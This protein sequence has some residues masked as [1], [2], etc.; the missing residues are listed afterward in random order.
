[1]N[2]LFNFG[3]FFKF[4]GKNKLYTLID[5]FGLSVSLMFVILIAI[6]TTQEL[7]TDRFHAKAD[8]I[9]VL[10]NDNSLGSAY[11][12]AY[13]I[14]ER[15]P[16][17]EKVCPV[18]SLYRQ[19]PVV[20][21]ETKLNTELLFADSTFFD[22]F[23]FKLQT[24][25]PGQTLGARNYAV[26]SRTFARKAFGNESPMGKTIVLND[27]VTVVVNGVMDDIKNSTLPYCDILVRIDNVKHFNWTLDSETFDNASGAFVFIMEKENA[28]LQSRTDDMLAFFKEIFWIYEKGIWNKVQLV[29][30]KE[31]YFSDTDAGR[32]KQGEWRLVI[33][34]MSVGIAILIFALINYI[35]LTVAQSGFRAKEMATRRLLGSSRREL[36][37]RLMLESTLLCFIASLVALFLAVLFAPAAGEL[38]DT[39]IDVGGSLLS[40]WSIPLALGFV[41][42]VG[43]VSGLMPAMLISNAKPIDI[44]RGSFIRKNKMVFSRFFIVFQNVITIML[45]VASITMAVQTSHLIHAPLGYNTTNI[46]DVPTMNFQNKEE[47]AVFANEAKQL[48]SVKRVG[49]S[50]STPFGGGNNST[51]E[52]NGKNISFQILG[53]DSATFE[54]LGLKILK[55]NQLGSAGGNHAYFSEQAIKETEAGENATE[56]RFNEN[57]TL[58]IDGIIK[59]I[60]LKNITRGKAPLLFYFGAFETMYPWN[61]LIEVQGDP[62]TAFKQVQET[63]ERVVQLDFNGTFVDEQ[64]RKSFASQ[65]RTS[66][67]VSL[68]TFIAI[69]ISLLG[70]VAMSTYFIRQHAKEI[71]IRKVHGAENFRMLSRL[72]LTFLG[73]VGIAFVI[74]VPLIRY[75]MK[76]WLSDYSYRISLSPWIFIAAGGFCLLVSFVSVYWQ[77]YRAA[78]ANPVDE[79]KKE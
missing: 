48:A 6:Y 69:L 66:R 52:Y 42:L 55:D 46:L 75:I 2:N 13:R 44:T 71:A 51:V 27:S 15:F 58:Q 61:I 3:T 29:P 7:S 67:I 68:F 24:A 9:Y 18:A 47:M 57:W 37:I 78:H 8:R 23:D 12:L 26:I 59:D 64:V 72:V 45:L 20:I 14:E 41:L 63:Y 60:Q 10:G 31:I 39:K 49:F 38:L 22:F 50:Q 25:N 53:G 11:R 21:N 16:E 65:Q 73:Y 1:M 74:A 62:V 43:A 56:I 28:H 36:F 76:G 54:M 5:V 77:S 34:L 19:I 70:L 35:N 79:L 4:L 40:A 17:I 32:L 30:L 33:I